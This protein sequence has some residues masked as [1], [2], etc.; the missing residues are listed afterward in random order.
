MKLGDVT[1]VLPGVAFRTR[2]ETEAGGTAIVIQARDLSEIGRI[3]LATAARIREAPGS[4]TA[5][6]LKGDVVLQPRGT[7]FPVGLFEGAELPAF[8]AAPLLVIRADQLRIAPE[9][10]AL[11]L[12]APSI[13]AFLRQSAAGTYVP[14]VPRQTIESLSIDL[15]ELSIQQQLVDLVLCQRREAEIMSRL[16]DARER[17]FELAVRELAK[18]SRK[19]VSA[20]GSKPGLGDAPTPPRPSSN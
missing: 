5:K 18:K 16:R 12:Q 15:P 8:A 10:L 1:M 6:L 20:S 17:L 3:K 2:I 19:R 11:V 9:F 4:G 14:Q 7:R 13:Q